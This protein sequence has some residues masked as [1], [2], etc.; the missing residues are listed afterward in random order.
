MKTINIAPKIEKAGY[1]VVGI[2]AAMASLFLSVVS[3]MHTTVVDD[4]KEGEGV[5]SVVYSIPERL[6]CVYYLNDNFI[7]NL[8]ILAVL[9]LDAF[10]LI[11]HCKKIKLRTICIGLFLWTFALGIFW[12]LSSQCAP[13][14]DSATVTNASVAFAQNDYSVLSDIRYFNEYPFQLG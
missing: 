6:E 7:L 11:R 14:E 4:V 10:L 1:L 2:I 5:M 9:L 12:V 13:T 3:L 8:L